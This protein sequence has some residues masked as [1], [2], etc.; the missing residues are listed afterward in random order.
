MFYKKSNKCFENVLTRTDV[1]AIIVIANG[2]NS[3]KEMLESKGI[4]SFV[5]IFLCFIFISSTTDIRLN[6]PNN[7]EDDEVILNLN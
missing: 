5:L 3:M 4:L 6:E 2:G 1:C 7:I